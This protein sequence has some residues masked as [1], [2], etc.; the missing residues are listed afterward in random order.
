[1]RELFSFFFLH[2]FIEE[3]VEVALAHHTRI[4]RIKQA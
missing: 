3:G 4:K 1:M 2:G